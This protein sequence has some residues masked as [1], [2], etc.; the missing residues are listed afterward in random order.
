MVGSFRLNSIFNWI[1]VFSKSRKTL[2]TYEVCLSPNPLFLLR[3]RPIGTLQNVPRLWSPGHKCD[4]LTGQ[5][6]IHARS[7]Q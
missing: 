7:H 1:R 2:S 6:E 5:G 3:R 4:H